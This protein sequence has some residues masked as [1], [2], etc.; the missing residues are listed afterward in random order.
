MQLFMI[1]QEKSS[2]ALEILQL[3]MQLIFG[4]LFHN[5]FKQKSFGLSIVNGFCINKS[6]K[7]KSQNPC[8]K[9]IIKLINIFLAAF[10]ASFLFI[11][12]ASSSPYI[13]AQNK[14]ILNDNNESQV[15]EKTLK[16][17]AGKVI[18]AIGE[19]WAATAGGK[20]RRLHKGDKIYSK[21]II[22]TKKYSLAQLRMIDK[23]FI[24][25]NARSQFK[26]EF[27]ELG[28][29]KD[30]D[31]GIFHLLKGGFRA[32][33][34]IIG[35]RKRGS[36]KVKT[37]V[38][39]IGIRGTDY[40]ARICNDDCGAPLGDSS[41]RNRTIKN[42]LYVGV[43]DG[44][45]V[46]ANK[47]GQLELQRL[48]YGFVADASSAP[49]A[50]MDA[51]KFIFFKTKLPKLRDQED[52]DSSNSSQVDVGNRSLVEPKTGDIFTES[53]QASDL[54]VDD[55]DLDQNQIV[56]QQ[57]VVLET[58]AG[59]DLNDPSEP[60]P[61]P[62][63]SIVLQS[64]SQAIAMSI[65]TTSNAANLTGVNSNDAAS[66]SR[67]AND[68]IEGFSGVSAGGSSQQYAIGTAE[69]IDL[70][71]DESTG[72]RWGR[73]ASGVATAGEQNLDLNNASL[74]WVLAPDS[75][76]NI[77]LPSSG[78]VSYNLVGNT[79]PTDN[80]G[81]LGFLGNAT[82]DADFSNMTVDTRI[83]VGINNQL[84]SGGASG[85]PINTSGQ[86][87][88][89]L[90]VNIVQG[91]ESFTGNGSSS[92]FFTNNAQ[93]SGMSYSMDASINGSATSVSGVAVFEAK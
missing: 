93:A 3:D 58:S 48:H 81:N 82:L 7:R 71:L 54:N 70:G 69:N 38:G 9:K 67:D 12:Q 85:M 68:F 1:K 41:D 27:F 63:T 72:I 62:P 10:I 4:L 43:L 77:A 34:G 45:I 84:W 23:G 40:T 29:T 24:S 19:V 76:N 13:T 26:I 53:Q 15:I 20:K 59:A 87:S 74:H 52:D 31:R 73:W 36:Y 16:N 66:L 42:G 60:V 51:P 80:R 25:I 88:G 33:T 2:L 5:L 61:A 17:P 46:L 79:S 86:Y 39:T 65:G 75:L 35:K 89:A 14:K 44:G 37:V 91:A 6:I 83:D 30:Q 47:M 49:R 78:S 90:N 28:K 11:H 22:I 56:D 64:S 55:G 18:Y 21:D 57:E 50:L 32:I 8:I 92:G